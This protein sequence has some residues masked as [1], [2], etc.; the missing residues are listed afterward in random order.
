MRGKVLSLA[1]RWELLNYNDNPYNNDDV[2]DGDDDYDD[3]YDNDNDVGGDNDDDS[4]WIEELILRKLLAW[5]FSSYG[6]FH[7]GL[8]GCK[9]LVALL[10]FWASH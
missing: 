4:E 9:N 1:G 10:A 2:D 3:D 7:L 8:H 6:W 5:K